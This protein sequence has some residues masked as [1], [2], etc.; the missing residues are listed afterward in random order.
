[1]IM[2]QDLNTFFEYLCKELFFTFFGV[3]FS[4]SDTGIKILNV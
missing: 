4:I 3:I 1:M 2:L